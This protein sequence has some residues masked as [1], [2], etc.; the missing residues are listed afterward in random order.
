[1]SK[2]IPKIQRRNITWAWSSSWGRYSQRDRT[3]RRAI[4]L[5]PDFEK[6]HYGLG[7]ALRAQGEASA[8][9]KELDDLN[10]L[11]EFQ[12]AWRNRNILSSR[13]WKR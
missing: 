10:T 9:Q 1:V 7:I 13:A 5:K 11:H 3:F 2:S 6:A 4:E 8:A 12:R